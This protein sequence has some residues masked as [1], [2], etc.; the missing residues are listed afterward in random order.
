VTSPLFWGLLASLAAKNNADDALFSN[1]D[2]IKSNG[3]FMKT[4]VL[5]DA[6]FS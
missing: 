2:F 1:Y 6:F 4:G 3:L 5:N